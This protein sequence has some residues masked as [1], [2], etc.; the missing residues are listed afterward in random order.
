MRTNRIAWVIAILMCAASVAAVALRPAVKR[1]DVAPAFSLENAV[2]KAFGDWRE[3]PSTIAQVVNPET[4][5][6]LNKLY[7]QMVS[8]VYVGDDGYRIMLSIAYGSDQ[9]RSLQVHKPEVCY[10]AQGFTV[11]KNEAV[12]IQTPF[13][14]IPGRRM[15][16]RMG[17]RDEPVTYWFT[18][19][20]KV[21]TSKLQKRLADLRY[22][23]TGQIPD[24]LIFRVS[25]M[26]SDETRSNAMQDKFVNQLLESLK[27]EERK[28]L[29]GL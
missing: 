22:G 10:P 2:P 14:A 12:Q 7:S 4:Q 21:V 23:L 15:F 24:G 29:S 20:D 19:G 11:L 3:E 17:T 1:A 16:T 28:R 25:S 5:A 27:P 13:G 18:T 9:R 6:L 8:R 26:D